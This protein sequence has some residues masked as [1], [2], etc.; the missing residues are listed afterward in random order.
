MGALAKNAIADA[1][2]I[3][4]PDQR[5]LDG[6]ALG[7][8][9]GIIGFLGG[10]EGRI[11]GNRRRRWCLGLSKS[12]KI[13]QPQQQGC[14]PHNEITLKLHDRPPPAARCIMREI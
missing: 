5:I 14:A 4:G 7:L 10:L 6:E 1:G 3:I 13:R 11:L 9:Q 8:R 12:G 2:K